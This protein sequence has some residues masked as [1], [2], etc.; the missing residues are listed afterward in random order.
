MLCQLF[1]I[2]DINLYLSKFMSSCDKVCL[3]HATKKFCNI[4]VLESDSEILLDVVRYDRIELLE[5][6]IELDYEI[7]INICK[8]AAKSGSQNTFEWALS[9]NYRVDNNEIL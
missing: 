3:R 4:S 2:A 6:F 1:N 9:D 8:L 7:P 5:Y